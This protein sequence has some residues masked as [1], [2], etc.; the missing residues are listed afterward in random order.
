MDGYPDEVFTGKVSQVRISPTTVSNVVTYSV[1]IDVENDDL[2]LIPGMTA[3]VSII[4]SKKEDILC[5]QNSALKFTPNTDGKGERYDKQG[6]WLLVDNEPKRIEIETGLS[7]D[8]FTEIVSDKIKDGDRA[9]VSIA[10][11]NDAKNK[12]NGNR[13]MPPRMF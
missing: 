4:T 11:K 3:N 2:K 12:S 8:T 9:I 6:I 1:I 10:D 5:V 13:K 7:D